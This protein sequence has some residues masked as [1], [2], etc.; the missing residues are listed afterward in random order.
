MEFLEKIQ[1]LFP[2]G[3][4]KNDLQKVRCPI[5]V[6]HGDQDPIVGVEHSHYV[7]KNISDSRLHRF[8]KG[9]HNLHFT[10][11][12]EFKQLVEDFLSD[13]DDGY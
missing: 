12:K 1:E 7:I 3:F 2:N 4:V 10:F 13:V 9:S 11:A 6:M 8:P 5:F